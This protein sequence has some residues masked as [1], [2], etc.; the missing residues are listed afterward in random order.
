MGLI[1]KK[2]KLLSHNLTSIPYKFGEYP[3]E[4]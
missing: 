1:K 4:L 3:K 2:K